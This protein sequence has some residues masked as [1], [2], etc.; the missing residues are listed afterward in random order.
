MPGNLAFDW[1]YG[2]EAAVEA[3]FAAAAHVTRL[4]LINNRVVCNA[5][6]P[7]ACVA[8]WDAADGSVTLHTCTQGGWG[9]RDTLA[10]EPGPARPTRSA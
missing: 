6:E 8:E 9:F 5:M 3:A 4:E 10:A 1:H 2:D 7:R